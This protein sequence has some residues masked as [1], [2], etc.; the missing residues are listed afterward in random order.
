M[1]ALGLT[2]SPEHDELT[3]DRDSIQRAG[4]EDS[5]SA[6]APVA[7]T[8]PLHSTSY[9]WDIK[10]ITP[11]IQS[12]AEAFLGTER[13]M[14]A[15]DDESEPSLP[16]APTPPTTI[17]RFEPCNIVIIVTPPS[18]R[19][20]TR[21][22]PSH[23]YAR[24]LGMNPDN[25]Q[26]VPHH[27]ELANATSEGDTPCLAFQEPATLAK[28][29]PV[30]NYSRPFRPETGQRD[31]SAAY[32]R[33]SKRTDSE[34][35]MSLTEGETEA[36]NAHVQSE[37]LSTSSPFG[38]SGETED[39]TTFLYMLALGGSI[40]DA[41]HSVD[42]EENASAADEAEPS[43][44]VEPI[45]PLSSRKP[46]LTTSSPS[47]PLVQT[48]EQLSFFDMLALGGSIDD[49]DQTVDGV[50]DKSAADEAEPSFSVEPV[51]ALMS[52]WSA[53]VTQS[54]EEPKSRPVQDRVRALTS[55]VNSS[56]R[57]WGKTISR[58]FARRPEGNTSSN[59]S[60]DPRQGF[61][62]SRGPSPE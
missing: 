58:S 8:L 27:H 34:L 50:D 55:R 23:I 7:T 51:P 13:F 2:T 38:L 52:R 28:P 4:Q 42:G 3:V 22:S 12:T 56:L 57:K 49:A 14:S 32:L 48:E 62:P 9:E 44:G 25:S 16:A 10:A 54:S 29:P 18:P 40:D 46:A 43:V 41:D 21:P 47:E 61:A 5:S 60:F 19:S 26:P 20:T 15:G 30:K 45:S 59:P 1:N 31:G 53:T 33:R 6:A 11:C 39:Q 36:Q 17:L 24:S 37:T 35:F